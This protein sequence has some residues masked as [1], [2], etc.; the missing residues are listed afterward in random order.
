MERRPL[1]QSYQF[2]ESLRVLLYRRHRTQL[3]P[4]FEFFTFQGPGLH[5][6]FGDGCES[7][8]IRGM[9]TFVGRATV[10]H[11]D[12]CREGKH[13]KRKKAKIYRIMGDRL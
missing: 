9:R 6:N 3:L 10:A 4:H 2:D 8:A 5:L 13:F 12:T 1:S 7:L 11:L